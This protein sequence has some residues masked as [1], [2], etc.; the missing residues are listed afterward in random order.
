MNSVFFS[1]LSDDWSTPQSVYSILNEE[2][3]FTFDPC[4]LYSDFDGLI[5][6]WKDQVV[7]CN[8]PYSDITTW[9][10][11]AFMECLI[12]NTT[13]VML[14]PARTDTKWFHDYILPFSEIRFIRGRLKFGDHKNNAPFPSMICIF[15]RI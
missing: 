9:V 14:L 6:S 1:S 7:F 13:V 10:K 3:H 8:P 15:R 2:F 4:P 12:N 11:K 5:L